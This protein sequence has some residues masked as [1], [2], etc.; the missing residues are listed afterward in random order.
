MCRESAIERSWDLVGCTAQVKRKLGMEIL[1][2]CTD[3]TDLLNRTGLR[4]EPNISE[5]IF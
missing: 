3:H 5:F 2:Y 4:L 1:T